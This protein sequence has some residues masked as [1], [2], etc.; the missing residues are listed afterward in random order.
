[1]KAA[2]IEEAW[3]I[4][5]NVSTYKTQEVI[6]LVRQTRHRLVFLP[7]YSPMMNPIERVFLKIRCC[8]RNILADF[9]NSVHLRDVIEQPVATFTATECT[10]YY[11]HICM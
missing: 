9:A 6:D 7:P 3:F 4:L 10:N 5:D 2:D 11:A 1:M 8:A